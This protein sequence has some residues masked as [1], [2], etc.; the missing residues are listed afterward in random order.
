MKFDSIKTKRWLHILSAIF[1][2]SAATAIIGHGCGKIG[3]S[4]STGSSSSASGDVAFDPVTD[5][6][7]LINTRT[8]STVYASQVL[9]N[10]VSCTQIGVESATTRGVWETSKGSLSDFG[11]ATQISPAMMM[12]IASVAGEVCNDLITQEK[13]LAPN[14]RNVFNT[15]DFSATPSR[16]PNAGDL[17]EA[18]LRLSLLCWARPQ[19]DILEDQKII[20]EEIQSA[21]AG[22]PVS[23][24]EV[25]NAALMLCTGMLSS[26]SAI[27]L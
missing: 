17:D 12:A 3:D 9:S 16:L 25:T 4:S 2:V 21:L 27:E 18:S 11:F 23:S 22:V 15:F 19:N 7:P 1:I 10:F 14:Q 26:L 6:D 5:F 13:A 20:I 24:R 8:V